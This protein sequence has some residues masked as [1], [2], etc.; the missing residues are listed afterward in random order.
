MRKWDGW[1]EDYIKRRDRRTLP[2]EP[3]P[4]SQRDRQPGDDDE[5]VFGEL[6]PEQAG[7]A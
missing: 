3:I 5:D 7:Q 6:V 2:A 4:P 1:Y